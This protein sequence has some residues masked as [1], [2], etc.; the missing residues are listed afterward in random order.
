MYG[1]FL[2]TK[3]LSKAQ[4]PVIRLGEANH[5]PYHVYPSE[6]QHSLTSHAVHSTS[7]GPISGVHLS[8][9]GDHFP[10]IS[11]GSSGFGLGGGL[12]G[13]GGLNL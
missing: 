13:F 12:G 11:L 6:H 10:R 3:T 7:S 1:G 4:L 8:G 9:L 5:G 2:A